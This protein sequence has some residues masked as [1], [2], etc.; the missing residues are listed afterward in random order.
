MESINM[1]LSK[2]FGV[3][4]RGQTYLNMLYLLLAFPLGLFYFVFL[5]TGLSLGISL[6]IV[7]VGFFVLLI[8][9]T[10]WIALLVMERYLAIH[11]LHEDIPPINRESFKG[12]TTWQKLKAALANP[13]TWKGLLFLLARFPL[14]IFSFVV[15]VTM[16]S[17]S[18]S[19]LFVP[20]YYQWIHP[21]VTIDLGNAFR[22]SKWAVDTLQEALLACLAGVFMTFVSLHIFNGL[23]WVSGKFARLMLGNFS[24]QPAAPANLPPSENPADLDAPS[25]QEPPAAV[26]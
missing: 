18:F 1:V 24:A 26:Q 25:S 8:V 22:G 13:V 5:V 4:V 9:F 10:A 20:L 14:G 7:W 19:L 12:K 16:I 15:L 17:L 3:A 11:L 23:A 21:P 6:V 2:F